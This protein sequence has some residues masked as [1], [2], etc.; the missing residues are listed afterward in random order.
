MGGRG[1]IVVALA[2]A[3]GFVGAAR[4]EEGLPNARP[5]PLVQVL[6]QPE[7]QASFQID[8]REVARYWF[9]DGPRPF[10]FPIVGP[11]GR[12]LTRMGHP[13]DPIGHAHHDSFWV[14][15]QSVDGENYWEDGPAARI[16]PLRRLEFHDGDAEARMIAANEWV[17]G[18]AKA[19]MV[20][21]RRMTVH[22]LEN[23]EWLFVLDLQ[24]EAP[25]DRP[26]VLGQTPFGP[27]GVRMAKTIGVNDGGG[28]IRNSEGN[29]DEQGPNGCFRKPA[30]WVD[31][32]GPITRD[33][34]EGITLFDHP[35]NPGHPSPFHVRRDGWMGVCLTLNAP[36][37]IQPGA[38][39]LLR[40]ALYVHRGVPSREAID[41]VW[42]EFARSRP[43]PVPEK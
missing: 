1:W 20:D 16:V 11:S 41:A 22:P 43:A 32:S 21:R 8:G 33:A 2:A 12:S 29:E 39:L 9:G 3:W 10:V 13:R 28:R 15:H 14:S 27:V 25:D 18:D 5:V 26:T 38:P 24:L 36:R 6:P 37:T 4:A 7:D 17:G 23:G 19:H 31:Y 40:Y 30:R 35:T 34:A 42:S